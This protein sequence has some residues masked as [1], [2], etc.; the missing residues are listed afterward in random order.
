MK[1]Y[2]MIVLFL[3]FSVML[4]GC[5]YFMSGSVD[6]RDIETNTFE[7]LF[8]DVG[9]SILESKVIE[10]KVND[11]S[12]YTGN[13]VGPAAIVTF[14][15]L[16]INPTDESISFDVIWVY[17]NYNSLEQDKLLSSLTISFNAVELDRTYQQIIY[18]DDS[19]YDLFSYD[20]IEPMIEDTAYSDDDENFPVNF[21]YCSR[22]T[23]T[24]EPQSEN[25][26]HIE[27]K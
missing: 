17:P 19:D 26:I 27:L 15:Y 11:T 3:F 10:V 23:L 18:P 24:I 2:M 9:L 22:F 4:L 21:N 25:V 13:L 16:L 20:Y 1:K 14:D 8:D 6:P 12:D 7:L 5:D